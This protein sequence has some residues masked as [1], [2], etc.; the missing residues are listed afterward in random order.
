MLVPFE[1]DDQP[2][3][4]LK[5][6]QFLKRTVFDIYENKYTVLDIIKFL[7]IVQ[8]GVHYGIKNSTNYKDFY[9]LLREFDSRFTFEY[10]PV[11]EQ[12]IKSIYMVV[13]KALTPILREIEVRY[14][15]D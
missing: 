13:L 6:E 8:G 3:D 2:V 1:F 10:L 15:S 5:K 7:S 12:S 11:A 4:Y 9:D 14:N